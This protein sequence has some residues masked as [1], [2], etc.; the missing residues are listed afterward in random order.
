MKP[1]VAYLLLGNLALAAEMKVHRDL[2]YANPVDIARRLN[3]YAPTQGKD[4]PILFWIHGGG[5]RRGDKPSVQVK[6]QALVN[7]GFSFVRPT[8]DSCQ[9]LR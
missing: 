9:M 2:A 3:V 1:I 6:P 8:T 7:K 5:W 4:C